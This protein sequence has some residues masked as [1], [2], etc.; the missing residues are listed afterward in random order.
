M[1][2]VFITESL[3]LLGGTEKILT[4]KANYLA[5]HFGYDVTIITCTQPNDQPNAF[6]L[7]KVVK[8]INLGIPYYMQYRYGYPK[9]LWIKIKIGKELKEKIT[10]AIRQLTPDILISTVGF[11]ADHISKID[12]KAKKIIECHE[13][14][15]FVKAD[16]DRRR[17]FFTRLYVNLYKRQKY[18]QTIEKNADV[19]VTLTDG[20]KQLWKKAKHVEVIPNFSTMQVS[21]YSDYKNKRIIAVGRLSPEKG[22]ER[23]FEV[24]R[25]VSSKYSDW[26]LDIFGE[27]KLHNDLNRS[28]QKSGLKNI[29]IHHATTNISQEYTNSSI[30]VMTSRLEGFGLALLEAMKHG[31]PCIA[32]DCPFGPGSIII[33]NQNGYLIEDDNIT[34]FAEKLSLLMESEDTRKAFS[35]AAIERAKDFAVDS[36]MNKWKL[37][38]EKIVE[39]ES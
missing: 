36:V 28:I 8:Q 24:W 33:D 13:A 23:L 35:A 12:C 39:Q 4:E 5:Q 30:Y 16:L 6:P 37:L 38:F 7:S 17:S 1:K 3:V 19:I 10:E 9:R 18:I 29:H 32:F 15:Y 31:L 21:H 26:V 27:G 14:R 11:R 25:L 2:I 20:D 22:Y 34:L